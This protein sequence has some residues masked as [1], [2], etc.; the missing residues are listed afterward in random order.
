MY[1]WFHNFFAAYERHE[2]TVQAQVFC[3]LARMT[4]RTIPPLLWQPTQKRGISHK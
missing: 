4:A 1:Y 2:L 3:M